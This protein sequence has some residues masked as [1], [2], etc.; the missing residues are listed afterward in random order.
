MQPAHV[1]S[2]LLGLQLHGPSYSGVPQSAHPPTCSPARR[3]ARP[4]RYVLR[5]YGY[6]IFLTLRLWALRAEV[7][8]P[9]TVVRNL[10]VLAFHL[11][12]CAMQVAC[13]SVRRIPPL[14]CLQGARLLGLRLQGVRL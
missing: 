14:P 5:I 1:L 4:Y 6:V 11:L 9:E 7:M 3:H 10:A 13:C 2:Q 8:A 12:G